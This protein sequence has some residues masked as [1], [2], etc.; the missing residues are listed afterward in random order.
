[1]NL[2]ASPAY[3]AM[4]EREARNAAPMGPTPYTGVFG[5]TVVNP[6][7]AQPAPMSPAPYT[8]VFGGTV[9]Q[10]AYTPT[11][12]AS[13]PPQMTTPSAPPQ[14]QAQS[15]MRPGFSQN[16]YM[17]QMADDITRRVNEATAQQMNN[18]GRGAVANG[19]YGS[20]RTGI[21]QGLASKGAADVL[22]GNLANLYGNQFNTDRNY[23]LQS[24]ALDLNVHN[25]NQNWMQQGAMNQLSALDRMLGWNQQYGIGNTTNVQNTPLNYWQQ[26]ANAGSQMGGLGGS[27]SQNM[28]GNPWLGALGGYQLGTSLFKG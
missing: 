27:Q 20:S 24:D 9:S 8:G 23:G 12:P 5:G 11:Q 10:P 18:I 26:F 16:P 3:S 22:A 17:P 19:T 25:A 4:V 14:M 15:A 2:F 6:P 13:A 21:A 28:P 1:M 7:A